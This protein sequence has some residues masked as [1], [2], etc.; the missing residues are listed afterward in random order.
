MWGEKKTELLSL[1][2]E[3]AD[4]DLVGHEDR[5]LWWT[6]EPGKFWGPALGGKH[7]KWTSIGDEIRKFGSA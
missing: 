3:K 6:G 4:Q 5:L 1:S 2:S 7:G